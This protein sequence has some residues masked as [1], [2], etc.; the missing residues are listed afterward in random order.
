MQVS[1]QGLVTA[2][3]LHLTYSVSHMGRENSGSDELFAH[4]RSEKNRQYRFCSSSY[5]SCSGVYSRVFVVIK[6][7]T[8]GEISSLLNCFVLKLY[9]PRREI[10]TA[11]DKPFDFLKDVNSVWYWL[12]QMISKGSFLPEFAVTNMHKHNSSVKSWDLF[13]HH[14]W[15]QGAFAGNCVNHFS[16]RIRECSCKCHWIYLF[17]KL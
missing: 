16:F 4:I 9:S 6:L 15:H 14:R 11:L 3:V 8:T 10:I 1:D 5:S 17:P 7:A 13:Q 2:L 12:I